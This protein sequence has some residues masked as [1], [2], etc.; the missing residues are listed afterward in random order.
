MVLIV[1][2]VD[3]LVDDFWFLD[4]PL[5]WKDPIFGTL[6]V[7]VGFRTD[8]ASIP[9][10]FRNLPFLDRDGL[11]RR[12]AC[13]HDWLYAWQMKGKDAADRFLRAALLWEG[14]SAATA[15]AFYYA[16]H[17]FGSG[18]YNRDRGMFGPSM[19]MPG[20]YY[21]NWRCTSDGWGGPPIIGL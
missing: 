11:S 12:A 20:P 8:I 5:I 4:A 10:L 1:D 18:P 19:F 17:L 6:T 9:R 13:M 7:P 21:A 3:S 15:A 14:A 16:V 2:Q